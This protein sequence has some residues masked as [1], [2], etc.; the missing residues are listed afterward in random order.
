MDISE[1]ASE[2]GKLGNKKL[3]ETHGKEWMKTLSLKAAVARSKKAQ[4]KKSVP[5]LVLDTSGDR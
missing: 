3:I 5:I 1:M 2:L 4:E